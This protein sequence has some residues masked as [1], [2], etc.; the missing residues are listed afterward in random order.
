MGTGILKKLKNRPLS[1]FF[2]L[3]VLSLAVVIDLPHSFPALKSADE[4]T[5][6]VVSRIF[7][8]VVFYACY[9]WL[10]PRYLANRKF[11]IFFFLLLALINAVTVVGYI[12]MQLLHYAFSSEKDFHLFYYGSMH[13][14]GSMAMSVAAAFGIIFRIVTGW[15]EEMQN[16]RLMEQEKLRSELM[17]LKAQ[18]N[19]HF[20]FNT[21]NNIDSLIHTDQ[22]KAS[23]ALI[24]LSSLLRYVIYDTVHEQVPLS[25]ELEQIK[26]YIDLHRIRYIQ[27]SSLDFEVKGNPAGLMVAPMLF[28]PFVENAFK[29]SGPSGTKKLAI[30]ITIEDDRVHFGCT[31]NKS[32]EEVADTGGFGL[33]NVKKRLNLQYPEKHMLQIKSSEDEYT[34]E[35]T[36]ILNR[37]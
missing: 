19:P 7:P 20:L 32:K 37:K 18:V 11:L 4:L 10:V 23:D 16:A 33:D 22:A 25:L 30:R 3:F 21:L 9:F 12:S 36:L 29:H 28:I 26:S 17:L 2:H 6:Y 1:L 5:K 13:L 27:G 34:A 14:S 35:L 31:N 8:L 24:K 15:Y